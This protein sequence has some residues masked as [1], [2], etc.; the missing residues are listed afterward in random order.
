MDRQQLDRQRSAIHI[1]PFC[2]CCVLQMSY[3]WR[4]VLCFACFSLP[5]P[6]SGHG[7]HYLGWCLLLSGQNVTLV[8]VCPVG[9]SC[10]V[11]LSHTS[12]E[13]FPLTHTVI[14]SF[15]FESGTM[16]VARCWVTHGALPPAACRCL[17]HGHVLCAA[18]YMPFATAH[19]LL[20]SRNLEGRG[21]V[22]LHTG[23]QRTTGSPT[24]TTPCADAQR[25]QCR[26]K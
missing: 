21:R 15:S 19:R 20:R 18:V 17:L 4:G 16:P 22:H 26:S 14:L 9:H 6:A 13:C 12:A 7:D 3:M 23:W 1:V 8:L 24:T 2:L 25:I 5:F 11:A 10:L